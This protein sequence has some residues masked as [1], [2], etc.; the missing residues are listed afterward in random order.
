M[1]A[2]LLALLTQQAPNLQTRKGLVIL[3]LQNDFVQPGGKF[4]V[5]VPA[6]FW[7]RLNTLITG[8]REHG[9]VL[10]VRAESSP[11]TVI[12]EPDHLVFTPRQRGKESKRRRVSHDGSE[13]LS[14]PGSRKGSTTSE[15]HGKSRKG[16]A[17]SES[18]SKSR[19]GSTASQGSTKAKTVDDE[20]FLSANSHREACCLPNSG[21]ADFCPQA[22]ALIDRRADGEMITSHYSAFD[23]G[24]LALA[25]RS[26][27]ITEVFICGCPTNSLVYA[28]AMDAGR[29]GV[30]VNL[31]DDCLLARRPELHSPAIEEL[32]ELVMADV[33]SSTEALDRLAH[34]SRYASEDEATGGEE[35]DIEHDHAG[36]P[37]DGFKVDRDQIRRHDL[38]NREQRERALEADSE[39][40][41]SP[42][43]AL[44]PRR[45]S[46]QVQEGLRDFSFEPSPAHRSL[47]ATT[48]LL[49]QAIAAS[50]LGTSHSASRSA[51]GERGPEERR[52]AMPTQRHRD[53]VHEHAKSHKTSRDQARDAPPTHNRIRQRDR[54][55]ATGHHRSLPQPLFGEGKASESA[56]STMLHDFLSPELSETVFDTLYKE[57][58]W[59]SM[60]HQTGE[61]PRLVSCQG[62]IYQDGS[63][64]IYRHPSDESIPL[65]PWT[66]TVEAIRQAAK[67]QVGHPL[68]HVLIQLYRGGTDYISEHSD[69]TLDIAQ[70]SYIVNVSFGAQRTMRLRS[71]RSSSAGNNDKPAPRTT[72][73]V[74]MPHNSLL[75]MSLATNAEYLHGINADKRPG[76]ELQ[77]A[78][79]AYG[80]AR[81]SLTFRHIATYL[82]RDSTL[83]WGQGATAKTKEE[84][85]PVVNGDAGE[86]ERLVRAFG[87]EN[88]ASAMRWEGVYG[89]GSN[90]LHLK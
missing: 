88:Q 53:G 78:E 59:Q 49:Q 15:G 23:D 14:P 51:R 31:I 85:R 79:K 38:P 48:D 77:E 34:P 61:V 87:A 72:H 69:K 73:R 86:S 65:E 3:G 39:D 63:K 28:T 25:L 6:D 68:N 40:S 66:P 37:R 70:N 12:D 20:L 18:A 67:D 50:K 36:T 80:G 16:S 21:G 54:K 60:H 46:A 1:A 33:S 42:S 41:D 44:P 89:E 45:L 90:V 56:S 35:S 22:K 71:K 27:L 74:P 52:R 24:S 30:H 9:D 5:P 29:Y 4:P 19:Q 47:K 84:A 76:V 26:K 8:F 17:T 2:S 43:M 13:T 75:K 57:V 83:I 10:W 7:S 62:S 81:I 58:N 11:S 82:N 64:P 55:A 32:R